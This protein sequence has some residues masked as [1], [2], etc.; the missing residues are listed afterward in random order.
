[1]PWILDVFELYTKHNFMSGSYD[2]ND[3]NL[4]LIVKTCCKHVITLH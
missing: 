3:G 4:T 2:M 1:M